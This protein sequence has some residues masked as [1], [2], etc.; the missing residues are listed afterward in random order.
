MVKDDSFTGLFE[1]TKNQDEIVSDTAASTWADKHQEQELLEKQD[2]HQQRMHNN[3]QNIELRKTYSSNVFKLICWVFFSILVLILIDGTVHAFGLEF[4]SDAVVES[5]LV[6][7]GIHVVGMFMLI[8][9][10]LFGKDGK[11]PVG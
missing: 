1:N 3:S 10:Y 5:L 7:A 2:N 9:V 11:K 6:F 4:L 8:L